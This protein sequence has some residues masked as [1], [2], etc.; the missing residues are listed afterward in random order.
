MSESIYHDYQATRGHLID[1][2]H[3]TE[4]KIENYEGIFISVLAVP[5]GFFLSKESLRDFVFIY[6]NKYPRND[7]PLGPM[8]MF[9]LKKPFNRT[10]N[11]FWAFPFPQESFELDEDKGVTII[12]P[13]IRD[14]K[15]LEL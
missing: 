15:K 3:Q 14:D 12:A 8:T 11:Q 9:N 10:I 13:I 6:K 4:Q 7:D 1:V 5:V 2:T